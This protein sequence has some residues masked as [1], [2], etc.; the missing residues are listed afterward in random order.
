MPTPAETFGTHLA[1]FKEE[2]DTPWGRLRHGIALANVQRHLPDG[3]LRFLDVGGG[4]G[5]DAIPFAAE[6]HTVTLLDFSAEMLAEARR[7]AREQ[8]VAERMSFQQADLNAIPTLFPEGMF[9]VLLCHNVLQHV[10]D[11]SVALKTMLHALRP[12]GLL[13]AVWINPYSEPY[14]LAL[15]QLDLAAARDGLDA[16][17]FDAQVFDVPMRAYSPE[18]MDRL[19]EALGCG[20]LGRY[21]LRCVCD[22]I[23]DNDIKYDPAFIAQ[24]EQLEHA[25]SSRY[26]YYLL[27]RYLQF[28]VRNSP[29]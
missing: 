23:P 21:G 26:P 18:E 11:A 16:E 29:S 13:S 22:Y 28:I 9:D 12:E 10:D 7:N 14:R 2:Q 6:G 3:P 24:L 17:S 15:Q 19:L 8:G 5:L 4:H 25:M 1:A 27:A 20:V